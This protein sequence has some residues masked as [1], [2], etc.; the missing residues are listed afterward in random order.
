MARDLG[1]LE[2]VGSWCRL[3]LAES[4]AISPAPGI[5]IV[6]GRCRT[7]AL[8]FGRDRETYLASVNNRDEK[9]HLVGR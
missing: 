1:V 5:G 8:P 3:D 4:R 9:V 6:A 7:I 2:L